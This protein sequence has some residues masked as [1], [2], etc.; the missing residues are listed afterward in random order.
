MTVLNSSVVQGMSQEDGVGENRSVGMNGTR[1]WYHIMGRMCSF[2]V[3]VVSKLSQETQ[4][5]E[6]Q[7]TEATTVVRR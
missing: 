5:P 1:H 7:E 6:D 4:K 3:H 2:T